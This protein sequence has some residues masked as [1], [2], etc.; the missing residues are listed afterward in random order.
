[1]GKGLG[2]TQV[3]FNAP[4]YT[5]TISRA[6]GSAVLCVWNTQDAVY[7]REFISPVAI[8]IFNFSSRFALVYIYG[9]FC[10]SLYVRGDF[11]ILFFDYIRSESLSL[12]LSFARR[13]VPKLMS[14]SISF[15]RIEFHVRKNLRKNFCARVRSCMCMCVYNTAPRADERSLR[16]YNT[17]LSFR[18][19]IIFFCARWHFFET[20]FFFFRVYKNWLKRESKLGK[21]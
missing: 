12:S 8:Y 20:Q 7:I 10:L 18:V 6:N 5:R 1:M 2:A 4:H 17:K 15:Q 11:F 3:L 14:S 9:A 16:H 21:N 13:A 19:C